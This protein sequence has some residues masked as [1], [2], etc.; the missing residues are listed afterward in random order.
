MITKAL[1]QMAMVEKKNTEFSPTCLVV[2]EEVLAGSY[3]V[4]CQ[5]SLLPQ[6]NKAAS[7]EGKR[8]N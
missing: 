5:R 8:A 3:I 6:E 7:R 2:V 1:R 4:E